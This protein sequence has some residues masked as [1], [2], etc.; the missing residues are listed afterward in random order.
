MPLNE[1]KNQIDSRHH[2]VIREQEHQKSYREGYPPQFGSKETK[3][4][5]DDCQKQTES[6]EEGPLRT[7]QCEVK[8]WDI[9]N[10]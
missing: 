10:L 3:D 7:S 1:R 2:D 6:L 9:E 4:S 8:S 5:R